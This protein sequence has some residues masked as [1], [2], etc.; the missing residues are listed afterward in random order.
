MNEDSREMIACTKSRSGIGPAF[1]PCF[2][3]CFVVVS[4]FPS[5][6]CVWGFF[7]TLRTPDLPNSS[8]WGKERGSGR[9]TTPLSSLPSFVRRSTPR[10]RLSLASRGLQPR[11]SEPPT[12]SRRLPRTTDVLIRQSAGFPRTSLTSEVDVCPDLRTLGTQKHGC[13]ASVVSVRVRVDD[14]FDRLVGDLA[15]LFGDLLSGFAHHACINAHDSSALKP[16]SNESGRPLARSQ[17]PA[18]IRNQSAFSSP[19]ES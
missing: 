8:G 6:I 17:T 3:T 7:T 18:K 16:S 5:T 12:N 15:K 10:F 1:G 11:H 9:L 2:G 19:S 13:S 14:G 4:C